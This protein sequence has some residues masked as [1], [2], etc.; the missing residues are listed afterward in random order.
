VPVP[1]RCRG[2]VSS[3][4]LSVAA[5]LLLPAC[6][7]TAEERHQRALAQAARQRNGLVGAAALLLLVLALRH[8][9][10]ARRP[11]GSGGSRGWGTAASAPPLPGL[12]VAAAVA[13]EA[14]A[15]VL[16]G[17]VGYC[18]GYVVGPT[19]SY[20]QPLEELVWLVIAPVVVVAAILG[21]RLVSLPG[22]LPNVAQSTLRWAV[23][24][25][26]V[27]ALVG[28]N[29]AFDVTK[30]YGLSHLAGGAVAVAGLV[31]VFGYVYGIGVRAGVRRRTRG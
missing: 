26:A 27:V 25:H 6:T 19:P 14:A 9:R 10:D 30:P 22:R 2:A 23:V 17:W 21:G 31:G 5:V 11:G 13:S 7:E 4:A 24:T 15:S 3:V 16:L 1:A 12:L 8:V 28:L 29:A 18:V 20:N